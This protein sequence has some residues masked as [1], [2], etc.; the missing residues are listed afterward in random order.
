MINY[1][2]YSLL[3][4]EWEIWFCYEG[5]GPNDYTSEESLL[6][7][8]KDLLNHQALAHQAE[9]LPDIIT[10]NDALQAAL[11]NLYNHA[12]KLYA[13][14]SAFEPNIELIANCFLSPNYPSLHPCQ[15]ANR[16]ELWDALCD[17]GWNPL[18]MDGVTHELVL[19]R[20]LEVSF[21][22]FIG[23]DCPTPNWNEGLDPFLTKDLHL[24]SAF[25][26]LFDHTNF[27]LTDFIFVRDF[28]I[29]IN[30]NLEE[31]V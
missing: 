30:I 18:Y 27:A 20:D 15:E 22:A 17:S 31:K 3:Q 19:P 6:Q 9:L 4:L 8:R 12:H 1:N 14:V 5:L 29:E 25:H 7:L 28:N 11:L 10:F 21:D 2:E 16:Q 13:Q 23:M 26:N 24:I